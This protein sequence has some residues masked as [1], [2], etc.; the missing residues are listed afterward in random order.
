MLNHLRI[1]ELF[2]GFLRSDIRIPYC[3]SPN[4]KDLELFIVKKNIRTNMDSLKRSFIKSDII[5]E[6]D[7][8]IKDD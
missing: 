8:I 6:D 5:F 3:G 4:F 7:I 2:R 1:R